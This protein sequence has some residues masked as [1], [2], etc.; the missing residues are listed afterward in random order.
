MF[1]DWFGRKGRVIDVGNNGTR[2]DFNKKNKW[3]ICAIIIAVGILAFGSCGGEKKD[4]IKTIDKTERVNE[5]IGYAKEM[6][7]NL[8]E[9]LSSV[10]G[11]GKVKVMMSFEA[12]DE[13]VLAVNKK[14][15][16][17]T[18]INEQGSLNSSL[19]EES[20]I[21]VGSGGDEKPYVL[22]ERLP[23]PSGILITATGA[24]NE[25]VRLE[26]YEAVKALYGVSGH[27]I[28]VVA[29]GEKNK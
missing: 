17:E 11:A 10:K 13:K 20:V 21:L 15:S 14:S 1:G 2:S 27:R 8:E 19:D 3:L 5:N 25:S 18:E 23:A 4:N 29:A 7:E 9:M 28:K 6:A 16:T 26:L 12:F 22:S 24:G